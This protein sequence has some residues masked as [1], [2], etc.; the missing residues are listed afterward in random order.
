[1]K[2]YTIIYISTPTDRFKHEDLEQLASVAQDFNRSKNITGLL[3]YSGDHFMQVLEGD[4]AE[5]TALFAS[6]EKDTRHRDIEVLLGAPTPQRQFPAWSMGVVDASQSRR[7]DPGTMRALCDQAEGTRDATARAAMSV[8][9][10]FRY[11]RVSDTGVT[12][13][14]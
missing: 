7:L 4:Y 1:M 13:A 12:R 9:E 8:L 14:T 10:M 6:I 2:L 3:L 5:L 11:D